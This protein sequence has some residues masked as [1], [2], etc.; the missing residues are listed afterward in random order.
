MT[1]FLLRKPDGT[2]ETAPTSPHDHEVA[3]DEVCA[4]QLGKICPHGYRLDAE[5]SRRSGDGC[6]VVAVHTSRNA[7]RL[8][9]RDLPPALAAD[10]PALQVGASVEVLLDDGRVVKTTT[11]SAPWEIGSGDWLVQLVGFVG[12][13]N[14]GRLRPPGFAWER[15]LTP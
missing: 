15:R 7:L 8:G 12:G 4:V 11:R 10:L 6:P 3:A 9:V 1:K 5:G 13:Y 14:L 2:T